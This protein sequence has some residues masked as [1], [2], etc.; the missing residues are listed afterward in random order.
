MKAYIRTIKFSLL[1]ALMLIGSCTND[2]EEINTDPNR[3]TEAPTAFIFTHAQRWIAFDYFDTWQ[4]LRMNGVIA[5][6][7]AQRTYTEEDRYDFAGRTGTVNNFFN[8]TYL[9]SELLNKIVEVQDDVVLAGTYGDKD[10]QV[11]TVMILKAWLM[12]HNAQTYGDVPYRQANQINEFPNAEYDTEEFI[13]KA[14]INELKE[15]NTMLQNSTRGWTRGDIIFGGNVERWRRFANSLRLRIAMRLSVADPTYSATEAAAAIASGVMESNADNAVFRF[16]GPGSPNQAPKYDQQLTR[17]DFNPSW[18]FVNLLLGNNDDKIGFVNPFNGIQDPRL[19]QFVMTPNEQAAGT[20]LRTGAVP[21]GLA[22]GQNNSFFNNIRA[23]NRISYGATQG[24][25]DANLPKPMQAA[26]WSTFM[27]FPNTALL[28]AE[29]L[30]NDRGYFEAGVQ[31]SMNVWGVPAA[32]AT[33]YVDD[34]MDKF[35]AADDEGKL[36]MIITQKYIHNFAHFDQE[37]L[38]E[39]RRTEFPK[40]MVMPGQQTGPDAIE[41]PVLDAD[42]NPTNI[43]LPFKFEPL[44]YHDSQTVF[45]N[46]HMYPSDEHLFNKQNLDAAIARMAGKGGNK[47]TTPLWYSKAYHR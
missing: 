35:D 47:Q 1:I 2:F 44:E 46:R 29:H 19:V 16:T 33:A 38:F 28:I 4:G 9:I 15:A 6:K 45:F 41:D 13:Y 14:L 24:V 36:E 42:G 20:A 30:D 32:A 5:Q 17:R 23:A 39:Y 34:V 25:A 27:D 10:M 12:F 22:A 8:L 18:Q 37:S 21:I 40:S 43:G 26:M 3:T 11:A 7:W 31:A